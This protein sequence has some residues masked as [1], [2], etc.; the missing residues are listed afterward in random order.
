VGVRVPP[1]AFMDCC[2]YCS[3]AGFDT[4]AFYQ[5]IKER[6]KTTLFRDVVHVG[7]EEGKKLCDLFYFPYGAMISWGKSLKEGEKYLELIK[8]FSHKTLPFLE[9]DDYTFNFGKKAKVIEDLIIIPNK[10]V[11]TKLAISHGLAQSVKLG[12]FE[13]SI[14]KVFEKTRHLPEVLS[15]RGRIPLSRK[16][17]RKKMGELFLERSSINLHVDVLDTPEF[18]WEYPELEPLYQMVAKELEIDVRGRMLNHRLDVVRD[19]FEM[20]G[21]ELNN[22]HSSR[23]EWTIIWLIIIEVV[24]SLLSAFNF[25]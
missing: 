11:K 3:A 24:I 10:D 17:I 25:L 19:L 9:T 18:F 16:T 12:A 21:N 13:G 7:I 22:Q 1:F 20:L 6:Y 15:K 4:K 23:L 2:A 14:T 5:L 8:D